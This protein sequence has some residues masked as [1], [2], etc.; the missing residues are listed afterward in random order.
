MELSISS[1]RMS[2]MRSQRGDEGSSIFPVKYLHTD[3]NLLNFR[4]I[5]ELESFLRI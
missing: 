2:K 5:V 3:T 1:M 4:A